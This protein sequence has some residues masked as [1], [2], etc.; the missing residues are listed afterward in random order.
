[1][2]GEHEFLKPHCDVAA[3]LRL[4]GETGSK[5]MYLGDVPPDVEAARG[6]SKVA[7]GGGSAI[8][9]G[10]VEKNCGMD[11]HFGRR[12]VYISEWQNY[13]SIARNVIMIGLLN[14]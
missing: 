7:Y 12:C 14:R 6:G 2:L 4:D 8:K 1:M 5:G 11:E 10:G 9:K 3:R 13:F